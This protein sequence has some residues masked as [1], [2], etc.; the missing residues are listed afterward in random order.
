MTSNNKK[1]LFIVIDQLRADCL[2]GALADHV[3]LP[4][5]RALQDDAV[6]FLNHFTVASPCGPARASLLTGQY[7]MNHRAVFNGAPLAKGTPNIATEARK[8]GYDPLLFGYTD[9][10]PDPRHLDPNDP[11]TGDEEGL[12]EGFNE[13]VGMRYNTSLPWRAYLKGKGY[14][15]PDFQNF[16]DPVAAGITADPRPDDPAFYKSEDSDTAF[17]ADRFLEEMAIRTEENW[18]AH[19]TFIRPHPPFVAPEPYNKMY[20]PKAL[21]KPSPTGDT[22]LFATLAGQ[23]QPISKFV[24]GCGDITEGN[25]QTL[26]ALYLGLA[27][28]VDHHIGRIVQ[29][30][31]DSGQYDDTILIITADHGEMLG[32]RGLWAKQHAFDPSFHISLIIR[33]PDQPSQHGRRVHHLTESIDVA[34]TLLELIGLPKPP[35]MNGV[36]LTPFLSGDI[37]QD[38]RE[39]AHMELDFTEVGAR[40]LE[41]VGLKVKQANLAILRS[42]N[43]KLVHFAHYF[44][45]M[46]FDLANDPL[47]QKN[48]AGEPAFSDVMQD[49]TRA[50]LS[51]RMEHMDRS[52]MDPEKFL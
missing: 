47:E 31:K 16:Y 12:M 25:T 15:L 43:F 45:P 2:N 49:M 27:T 10:T 13:R 17:L 20:D 23:L 3:N 51:L 38:W 26:R 21:P 46:L 32:D 42:A 5:L 11:F 29:F 19:L 41:M 48:L 44:E 9:I 8:A 18:F 4:N 1:V 34:P 35:T 39:F 14:D 6:S 36:S 50:L 30:L 22:H 52:L 24:K 33:D 40:N 37:P 28:E 7:A